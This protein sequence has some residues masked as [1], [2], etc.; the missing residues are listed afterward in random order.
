MALTGTLEAFGL[1]EVLQL[2]VATGKTGCL[3]VDGDGGRGRVW[4][5]DGAVAA[6]ST[7]RVADGPL[8]E[9]LCDLLRYATGDFSFDDD[10]RS[11][12]ATASEPLGQLLERAEALAA[13]WGE[14]EMAVPSTAH[15]VRLAETLPDGRQVTVHADQ[16]SALAAVG[17]GCTVADL[18]AR[19]ELSELHALRTVHDLVTCGFTRLEPHRTSMRSPRPTRHIRA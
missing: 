7:D 5:R 12:A 19:L 16:W 13:E 3:S 4:V 9:V 14:L 17:D 8:D 6:G 15:W 11:P 10:E 1:A 18:A 2:L